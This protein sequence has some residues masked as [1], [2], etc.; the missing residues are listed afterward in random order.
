MHPFTDMAVFAE[1]V[2]AGGFRAAALR[3][4]V[5]KSAVSRRV[6]ELEERLG[7]QLLNR[8]TRR[9]GLTDVGRSYHERCLR[10]LADMGVQASV[11][12][13]LYEPA[14]ETR[15][16]VDVMREL[17][18]ASIQEQESGVRSHNVKTDD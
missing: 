2:A 11:G 5:S 8:T 16:P 18:A 1:V 13:E 12:A 17:M 14:F 6:A 9:I 15:R 7:V 3:L 4:N 10:I